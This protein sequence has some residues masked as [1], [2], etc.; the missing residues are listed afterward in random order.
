LVLPEVV[1]VL[2][3]RLATADQWHCRRCAENS[4]GL[5]VPM[6][7][8]VEPEPQVCGKEVL[9]TRTWPFTTIEL[10]YTYTYTYQSDLVQQN[11]SILKSFA[12]PARTLQPAN[13][14]M[15]NSTD[16]RRFRSQPFSYKRTSW[17]AD[18]T[19]AVSKTR[20]LQSH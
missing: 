11:K 12:A 20:A 1:L 6:G 5:P 18:K 14:S 4:S 10:G 9:C 13:R 3:L 15:V 17:H 19:P 2:H 16:V 8:Q 7:N